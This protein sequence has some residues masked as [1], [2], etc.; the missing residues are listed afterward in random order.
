MS[1]KLSFRQRLKRIEGWG[2]KLDLMWKMLLEVTSISRSLVV[3]NTILVEKGLITQ[4]EIEDAGRRLSRSNQS[5]VETGGSEQVDNSM[6]VGSD[7]GERRGSG[8]AE[9][10]NQSGEGAEDSN[11]LGEHAEG[12]GGR[13][14]LSGSVSELTG[15]E[16]SVSNGDQSGEASG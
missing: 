2:P 8:E 9:E 12:T 14:V 11:G 3:L 10:D 15:V 4:E 7:G 6:R 13:T 5:D 1:R 16:A